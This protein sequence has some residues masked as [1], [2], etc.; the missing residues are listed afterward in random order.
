MATVQ[1]Y[2]DTASAGGDGTTRN[3][4]GGTAAYA[5]LSSWEAN[6]GGSATDDYIVD[7]AGSSADTTGV[8]VDFT[9][10]IVTGSVLIRADRAAPDNDGFYA[11]P[12]V[13]SSSHY[14]LTPAANAVGISSN[15]AN[16]TYD[17]VQ[18][19]HAPD[20]GFTTFAFASTFRKLRALD[21]GGA[22]GGFGIGYN[23]LLSTTL[24]IENNLVVGYDGACIEVAITNFFT[25]TLSIYENT[26]YGNAGSC[27]GIRVSSGAGSLGTTDIKGNACANAGSNDIDTTGFQGGTLTQDDNATEDAT[28]QITSMV[29]DDAWT[30]PGNGAGAQ[31]TVKNASSVLYNAVNP[32]LVTTDITDFTRD[33]TNHDAGAF[34]FQAAVNPLRVVTSGMVW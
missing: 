24:V 21:T 18:A 9:V 3:H 20:G 12:D 13:I 32:T 25:P 4:S 14:R 5:S 22:G 2:V 23:G 16:T 6:S 33:G 11:G 27:D 26:C 8:T 15:E 28:G 1:R 7:C 17:G 29:P 34:E 10:N 19:T 30:S 31:F